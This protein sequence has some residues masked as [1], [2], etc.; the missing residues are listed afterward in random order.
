MG[1]RSRHPGRVRTELAAIIGVASLLLVGGAVVTACGNSSASNASP[2]ATAPVTP[3]VRASPAT[4]GE[5][6]GMLP[7]VFTQSLIKQ[8]PY[9][10][11]K[12]VGE[13]VQMRHAV[14]SYRHASSDSRL[15]GRLEVV[16]NGDQRRGDKS[17]VLWGTGVLRNAGG[18]WVQKWTGGIAAGGDVHHV[19][20][21]FKGT[22]DYAGLVAHESGS[23]AEAG[24]GF[25]PDIQVVGAGWIETSDGSAV[26]PAPGRGSTPAGWTPVVGIATMKQT[27]YGGPGPWVWDLKQSDPRLSGRVEGE[28]GEAGSVRPDGSADLLAS[29]TIA[30]HDGSWDAPSGPIQIRG[31]RPRNEHFMSWTSAGTGAYAGLTYHGFW[32]FPEPQDLQPGDTFVWAGWIQEAE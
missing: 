24:E 23:F 16:I 7:M 26:P 28:I 20:G 13:V 14:W 11:T 4:A 8:R 6:Q 30:N 18:A 32:Y 25:T 5:F 27:A 29:S 12:T 15:T 31:P 10:S 22:G 9:R 19:Y 3:A 21:T 2:A 1:I 17:A